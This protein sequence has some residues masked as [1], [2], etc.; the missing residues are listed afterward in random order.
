[1]DP[2]TAIAQAAKELFALGGKVVDKTPPEVVKAVSE[3]W[4]EDFKAWREFWKGLK[5]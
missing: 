5:P 1:M 2:I 4:L 3:A